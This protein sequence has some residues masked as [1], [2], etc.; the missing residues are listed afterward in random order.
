MTFGQRTTST[1]STIQK[2][3]VTVQ[4][5]DMTDKLC[6]AGHLDQSEAATHTRPV[7]WTNQSSCYITDT[8]DWSSM[9]RHV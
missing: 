3:V 1:S 9:T 6:G 4:S 8:A 5:D 2:L 7:V